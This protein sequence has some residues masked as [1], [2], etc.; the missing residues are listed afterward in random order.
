MLK[1]ILQEIRDQLKTDEARQI[2]GDFALHDPAMLHLVAQAII[3]FQNREI[4]KGLDDLKSLMIVDIMDTLG[5]IDRQEGAGPS[6][7][8]INK[9][10]EKLKTGP[11]KEW[12]ARLEKK[13]DKTDADRII[14][15]ARRATGD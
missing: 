15:E 2:A 7:E 11:S 13:L 3:T 14:R 9:V 6:E 1:D 10:G 5:E 8:W 4:I 12:I